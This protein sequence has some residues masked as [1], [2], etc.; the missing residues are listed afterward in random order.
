MDNFEKGMVAMGL[1]W[2]ASCA[3]GEIKLTVILTTIMLIAAA[4]REV[5]H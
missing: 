5:T 2:V 3:A 4:W 1:V